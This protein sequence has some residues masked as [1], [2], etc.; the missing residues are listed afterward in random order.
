MPSAAG[1]N[2]SLLH[3][4]KQRGLCLRRCTIDLVCQNHIGKDG[5]RNETKTARARRTIFLNDFRTG[6]V[7]RHQIRVN[8]MRLN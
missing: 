7:C 8:W 1:G 6:N 3:R 2:L 5:T 4:F